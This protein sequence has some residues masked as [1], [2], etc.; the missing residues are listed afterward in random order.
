[1]KSI[2]T[3]K[4]DLG[5][6][7]LAGGVRVSKASLRVAAYG[8]LDE[9]ISSMGCAR[10]MTEDAEVAELTSRIQRELF[11]VGA[12]LATSP[13]SPKKPAP[14]GPDRVEALTAEVHRFEALEGILSDWAVPGGHRAA[15]FF[16]ASRTV[17]RRAERSAVRL[18]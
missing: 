8:D 5:E 14:I 10:A 9:L 2:S 15:A 11:T 6:T 3:T 13:E 12:A 7:S 4:G 18:A 1:M 16:D 17:C